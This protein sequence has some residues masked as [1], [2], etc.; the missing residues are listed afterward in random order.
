MYFMEYR[1]ISKPS[2]SLV[3]FKLGYGESVVAEAGA[4]VYMKNVDMETKAFGGIVSGLKRKILGGESFFMNVF[5]GKEGNG[6]VGLAPP[7]PGDVEVVENANTELFVQHTSLLACDEN[8]NIDTKFIGFKKFLLGREGAFFLK[9]TNSAWAFLASFGGIE[10]IDLEND[11]F[12]VDNGN[13]VAF[14]GTLEWDVKP[15]KSAK[16][17]FFSGEG[18]VF[19][20]RGTGSIWIQTRTTDAFMNWVKGHIA[21]ESGTTG[22]IAGALITDILKSR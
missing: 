15:V 2:Y 6:I 22:G 17:F 4:M 16:S 21:V 10:R 8:T 5:R 1:I 9:L 14:T 13:I 7:F 11:E 3:E 20:F 19:E 18:F 12:I